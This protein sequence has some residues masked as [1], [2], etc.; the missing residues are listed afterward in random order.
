MNGYLFLLAFLSSVVAINAMEPEEQ[1]STLPEGTMAQAMFPDEA[2][3]KTLQLIAFVKSANISKSMDPAQKKELT[4]YLR[5]A[6]F[7]L[8]KIRFQLRVIANTTKRAIDNLKKDDIDTVTLAVSE[9]D[10]GLSAFQAKSAY[11]VVK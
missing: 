4:A 5:A 8:N 6:L 9:A 7:N 11:A 3:N 2:I 10:K 1:V